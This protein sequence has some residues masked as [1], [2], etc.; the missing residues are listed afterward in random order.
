MIM[1]KHKTIKV[2]AA[3]AAILFTVQYANGQS[4]DALGTYTPYSV[5]GIGDIIKS[6]TA[7]NSAMGGIGIGVRDNRIINYLNPAAITDRDTLSFMMDFGMSQK[8]IYGKG[9]TGKSAFNVFNMNHLIITLPLYKKSAMI[10]G[11]TPYSS[12]G[13]KF[14]EPESDPYIINEMGDIRY[15]RYG[16]G[17][18][19]KLFLGASMVFL[20]N[21]SIGAEGIHY[22]GTIDRNSDILFV[23]NSSYRTINT[24]MD[25]VISSLAAKFGLQYQNEIKKDITLTLGAT[26]HL[27]TQL[28]GDLTRYAY[29]TGPKGNKDT[30]YH[31]VVD[32][33]SMEIPTELGFGL[34]VKK[35][36]KWLVGLDY[37]RQD[38]SGVNFG[39]T[40]GVDFTTAVSNSFRMGLEYTPN[41]YD[42]RY[43]SRRIT[44]RGG[45]YY[46]NTYMKINGHQI[47][48]MGLTL[49]ATLPVMRLYNGLG[50]SV[51]L[52]QR[53]AAVKD[54][55]VRERYVMF[56]ISFSLHDLWFI[57][58]RYD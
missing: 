29:A 26:W 22:F 41:R 57:K 28:N 30:V 23:S 25:Y 51:D 4:T 9:L 34:S 13:Y 46:Q 39:A 1:R 44:Y 14:E 21:F 54:N 27:G 38:W 10:A 40:T 24:G 8:N 5:F 35:R 50:I 20:K 42:I 15:R 45:A 52:G 12:V 11:V 49:G 18:I 6:G 32:N 43:Y 58:Y 56:N 36:D 2:I 37:L 16:T 55:L 47:N 31:S 19:N 17:G 48:S 53:G 7:A 33:T 3:L